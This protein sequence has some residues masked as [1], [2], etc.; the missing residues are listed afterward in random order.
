MKNS[1]G[2]IGHGGRAYA[3]GKNEE[4]CQFSKCS[5]LS[6][7]LSKANLQTVLRSMK[8]YL[9]TSE[10]GTFGL[11]FAR[12]DRSGSRLWYQI[13]FSQS[14][15]YKNDRNGFIVPF[16]DRSH[17][18]V[19]TW[20]EPCKGEHLN[21]PEGSCELAKQLYDRSKWLDNKRFLQK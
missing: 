7:H 12:G 11:T 6:I 16:V 14:P 10:W 3:L 4:N 13:S 1:R 15:L 8:L 20:M 19:L 17:E 21:R 2:H 18:E 9:A 5:V